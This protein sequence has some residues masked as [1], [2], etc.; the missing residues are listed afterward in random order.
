MRVAN[1]VLGKRRMLDWEALREAKRLAARSR[2]V[3]SSEIVP[4]RRDFT[5]FLGTGD[6]K[7]A[8]IPLFR[9][10]D[11]YTGACWEWDAQALLPLFDEEDVPA[12]AVTTES[13]F[14]GGR[15]ADLRAV[16]PRALAPVLQDDLVID[17]GGVLESR[18][19]GADATIVPVAWLDDAEL[20]AI[21]GTARSVH[22]AVVL[23]VESEADLHRALE[24]ANMPLGLWLRDP[25]GRPRPERIERLSARAPRSRA[26]LALGDVPD[27]DTWHRLEG[28][29]DA[30]LVAGFL[31]GSPDPVAALGALCGKGA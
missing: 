29:V 5:A 17:P 15:A 22:M 20:D 9:R 4:S 12:L 8:P 23:A 28:L 30:A 31:F 2:E 11:P 21:V 7:C 1:A 14:H 24:M 3:P 18:L 25:D 26:L 19:L 27:L 10:R 13:V 16:A 6:R